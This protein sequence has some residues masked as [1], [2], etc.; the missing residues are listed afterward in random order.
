MGLLDWQ[1]SPQSCIFWLAA[2][3]GVSFRG[4]D[5]RSLQR[6]SHG[7]ETFLNSVEL[8]LYRDFAVSS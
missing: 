7:A 5:P 3:F 6:N 4:D 1:A 2:S 8:R